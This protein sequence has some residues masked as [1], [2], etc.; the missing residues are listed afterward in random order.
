MKLPAS[1]E[2]GKLGTGNRGDFD[3]VPEMFSV[4]KSEPQMAKC[5]QLFIQVV[6]VPVLV[7]LFFV[8][9]LF[10]KLKKRKGKERK[11]TENPNALSSK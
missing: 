3:V 2:H 4:K 7:I 10:L 1:G 11:D 6:D 9:S 5:L 8:L